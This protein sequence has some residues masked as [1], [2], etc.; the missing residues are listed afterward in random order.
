MSEHET[1]TSVAEFAIALA[2][3]SGIVVSLGNQPGRWSP[4]DRSRLLNVL[5]FAFGAGFMAYLPMGLAHSGLTGSPLWRAS[6]GFFLCFG[7]AG[8]VF[9]IRRMR[10]LPNDVRAVLHPVVRQISYATSA[11]AILALLLNTLGVGFRPHFSAY[12]LG[13]VV[14]LLNGSIQF[15][16]ILFVRPE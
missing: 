11:I 4:A 1:L 2:G 7:V 9:M 3:F 12:F 15:T 8:S 13:L 6:S 16:R 14:L 5:L 10:G